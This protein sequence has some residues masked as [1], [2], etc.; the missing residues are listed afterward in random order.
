MRRTRLLSTSTFR[1]TLLY[2]GLFT[3]SA[4]ALLGFVYFMSVQ[5]MER[6][7]AETIEAEITGLAEQY[8]LRGLRGLQRIIAQ[9]AAAQPEQASVYLLLDRRGQILAGNIAQWPSGERLVDGGFRFVLETTDRE[10]HRL[11]RHLVARVFILHE[12]ATLLVGR[13]IGDKLHAQQ[14][15]LNAIALGGLLMLVLGVIGGIVMS[16]WM[17]RRIDAVN[18]ATAEIMAG[19]LA[20]RIEVEGGDDEFDELA[21]NLNAMLERI[22]RL[23]RGMRQ[24]TDNV[25]HDLRTPLNRLRSRIEVALMSR[26]DERETRDLLEATL[27]E[28]DGLIETF[29]ALLSIARIE[30]GAQ[31]SEWETVDLSAVAADVFDLYE[32]LAEERRIKLRLDAP[33]PARVTGNRQLIAQAVA[34]ITDNAI[35]YT[36]VGGRVTVSTRNGEAPA[37]AVADNGPGIPAQL[38]E[39]AL[40]RFIRLDPQRSTPGNGLGLSLVSAVAKLHDARLEL[41]DNAPGL[42]VTLTFK[43]A[44]APT[45]APP[46]SEPLPAPARKAA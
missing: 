32:P 38:R 35:K 19:D 14:Q 15:L 44:A 11:T 12:D 45:E 20:R 33:A 22:E 43:P 27:R 24:V 40:E 1:L 6:Q 39:Q 10:G 8:R 21:T 16:R 46:E 3:L 4:L 2:L 7:T 36:P 23:L 18:R 31:Q 26:L 5:F 28:A 25:A 13:D 37:V 41:E 17:L 29:N 9:R 30:T 42:R 34:N